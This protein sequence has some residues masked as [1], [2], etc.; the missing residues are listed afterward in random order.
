[1]K[2]EKPDEMALRVGSAL[3]HARMACRMDLTEAATLLRITPKELGYYERGIS[4]MPTD[5]IERLILLGYKMIRM[6]VLE[7]TYRRYRNIFRRLSYIERD[8][9]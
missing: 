6:R 8:K 4:K 3:R 1:M 9:Q 2:S 7:N 5:I